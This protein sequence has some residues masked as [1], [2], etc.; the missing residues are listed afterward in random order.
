MPKTGSASWVG[1]G[2]LALFLLP[3]LAYGGYSVAD[4]WY[5]SY[6]LGQQEAELRQEVAELRQE[7]LRLQAELSYVRS[8]E[9]I[10]TVAREQL[11][12]ARPGD[13]PFVLVGPRPSPTP[14]LS[15]RREIGAL[16]EKPAWRRLL[17]AL[18][19]R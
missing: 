2:L 10:E 16:P 4:R 19:G 11:N 14:E 13:R 12:L 8:D 5:E 9:Y 3:A 15:T 6:L 18:F 1:A 17:E 7:N